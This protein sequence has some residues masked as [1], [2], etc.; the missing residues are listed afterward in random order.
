MVFVCHVILKEYVIKALY[1]F[2]VCLKV[3]HHLT[4]VRGHKH[5]GRGD[6]M[7]YVS[8]VISQDHVIK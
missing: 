7:V 2:M 1:D 8:H 5:C 6:I 4:K 3:P